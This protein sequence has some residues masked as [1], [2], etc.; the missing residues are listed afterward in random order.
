MICEFDDKD[1]MEPWV[2]KSVQ[3]QPTEHAAIGN[4]TFIPEYV[5]N[6]H[7]NFLF[8]QSKMDQVFGTYSGVIEE[9]DGT[10][11]RFNSIPGFSERHKARW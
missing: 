3:K 2:F 10:I 5:Y 4:L 1:L 7:T 11:T 6:K 8:V 9:A